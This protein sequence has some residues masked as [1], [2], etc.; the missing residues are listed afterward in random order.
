MHPKAIGIG[1]YSNKRSS[2]HLGTVRLRESF[3][4]GKKARPELIRLEIRND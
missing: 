2:Q 1:S 4:D 3:L